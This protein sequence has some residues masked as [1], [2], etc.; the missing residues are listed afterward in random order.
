MQ[1]GWRS[2]DKGKRSV[3]ATV[4]SYESRSLR[5][6][7][8][9]WLGGCIALGAVTATCDRLNQELGGTGFFLP[10]TPS[11]ANVFHH[12]QLAGAINTT[13]KGSTLTSPVSDAPSEESGKKNG[14]SLILGITD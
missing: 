3:R 12:S 9:L 7:A 5:Y 8:A 11:I 10:V 1:S 2:G 4:S 6:L 14:R 13:F